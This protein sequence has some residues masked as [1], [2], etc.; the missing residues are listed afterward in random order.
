MISGLVYF[1]KMEKN[2]DTLNILYFRELQRIEG[3]I[4]LSIEKVK[5]TANY[6]LSEKDRC[7]AFD[8]NSCKY[9]ISRF[10]ELANAANELRDVSF[11]GLNEE[12]ISHSQVTDTEIDGSNF[13]F[14][15]PH[16]NTVEF[17]LTRYQEYPLQKISLKLRSSQGGIPL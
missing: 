2:E 17:T 14:R 5:A 16:F 12:Y 9:I 6:A 1:F 4:Q 8:L 10:N 11:V 15:T 3:R 7:D 13:S